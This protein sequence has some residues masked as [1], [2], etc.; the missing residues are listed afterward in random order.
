MSFLTKSLLLAA[1][2]GAAS[3]QG[4]QP[5]TSKLITTNNGVIGGALAANGAHIFSPIPYAMPPVDELRWKSPQ[6]A[7]NWTNIYNANRID[8]PITICPQPYVNSSYYNVSEDCLYLSVTTPSEIASGTLL[9]VMVYLHGGSLRTG[10]GLVYDMSEL[11]EENGVIAIGINYRLG[12]L[13][14]LSLPELGAEDANNSTGTYGIQDQHMALQWINDNIEYF[15]GNKSLITVF[16][17]SAG[18]TSTCIMLQSPKAA[19]L[20]SRAIVESGQC[21]SAWTP[22]YAYYESMN[23]LNQTGQCADQIGTSNYT[24]CLRTVDYNVFLYQIK[25]QSSE[26][27]FPTIDGV[28]VLDVPSAAIANGH[29]NNVPILA[30]TNKDEASYFLCPGINNNQSLYNESTLITLL[31]EEFSNETIV[32]ELI[33]D[34]YPVANYNDSYFEVAVAILSESNFK[35]Q[36]KSF[37]E[38]IEMIAPTLAV[39]PQV[40]VYELEYVPGWTPDP[41][42]AVGH[43]VEL[44]FL[45]PNL[46]TS[47]KPDYFL[48]ATNSTDDGFTTESTDTRMSVAIRKLWATFATTGIATTS[49]FAIPT[50]C[51]SPINGTIDL[52]NCPHSYVKIVNPNENSN[53]LELNATAFYDTTCPFWKANNALLQN[54]SIDAVIGLHI[55]ASLNNS[56]P[57]GILGNVTA[58]G[59][60]NGN[61]TGIAEIPTAPAPTGITTATPVGT[62]TLEPT[63]AAPETTATMTIVASQ[64]PTGFPTVA[65]T[66]TGVN[67]LNKMT[68]YQ[69][70]AST[71][72]PAIFVPLVIIAA[73][74][75]F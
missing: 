58:P 15:G 66:G 40:Y 27:Y 45:F 21:Q 73:A 38:S 70:A 55:P 32:S 16:G 47:Y 2:A 24:N 44:P 63:S 6:P 64:F 52:V 33:N 67:G 11:V 5:T 20:F 59:V 65:P 49:D 51:E 41:C 62:T 39:A 3:A 37:V 22:E 71:A 69:S 46:I 30:G 61:A 4:I 31:N 57:T 53:S 29:F 43:S 26:D 74:L 48:N 14:F 13:G 34:V 54:A 50:Y 23:M 18:G 1:A 10:S 12:V 28:F 35:C 9:P 75:A 56:A 72:A 7:A 25:Q 8:P 60:G 68:T 36:I 19:G 17:E 42:Y